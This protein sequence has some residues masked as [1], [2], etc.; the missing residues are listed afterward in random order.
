MKKCKCHTSTALGFRDWK[1]FQEC[2]EERFETIP[3]EQ[4]VYCF[5]IGKGDITKL[6]KIKSAFR[7]SP[8]VTAFD[9]MR[10][11]SEKVSKASNQLFNDCGLGQEWGLKFP[12]YAEALEYDLNGIDELPGNDGCP[13]LY[14]GASDS[15]RER[16]K[17]VMEWKHPLSVPLWAFLYS[18]W[19][20]QVGV[21]SI[22][23]NWNEEAK[24]KREYKT[25]HR[26]LPFIVKR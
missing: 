24:I 10:I 1:P 8:L 6:K 15:L 26:K 22:T 11:V 19:T 25:D 18:G 9:K 4:G 20:I 12:N 3:Q 23:D 21:R 7:E 17:N 2:A 13:I 16:I 5:R 14:I